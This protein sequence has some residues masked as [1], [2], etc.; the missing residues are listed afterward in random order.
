MHY[1]PKNLH[2]VYCTL[3]TLP[4]TGTIDRIPIFRYS[5]S[6]STTN[7]LSEIRGLTSTNLATARNSGT[8]E[9]TAVTPAPEKTT[10]ATAKATIVAGKPV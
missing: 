5:D 8:S 1:P 4:E 10:V 3:S 2:L 9:S 7:R 6:Y